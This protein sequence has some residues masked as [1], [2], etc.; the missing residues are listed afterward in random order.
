VSGFLSR[1]VFPC[2]LVLCLTCATLP[3]FGAGVVT[4]ASQA[5]LLSA[6]AGGGTV[7]RA[8]NGT[9]WLTNTITVATNTV[10]IAS[11]HSVTISGSNAVQLFVVP[12]SVTFVLSNLVLADG[13]AQGDGGAISN[14]G[15]VLVIDC[16]FTNNGAQGEGADAYDQIS[17][18]TPGQG[19][20]IYNAGILLVTNCSFL[21]NWA[22]GGAGQY[23]GTS[24]FPVTSGGNGNGGAIYNI[25]YAMIEN[26]V[27]KF[28]SAIGGAPGGYLP[29]SP[30]PS[31]PDAWGQGAVG[32]DVN[33]GAIYNS[34]TL[35]ITNS[36]FE[37]NECIAGLGGDAQL[38]TGAV[39]YGGNGFAGGAGGNASGAGLFSVSGSVSIVGTTFFDNFASGAAGGAGSL[40][41][42]DGSLGG[43][44]GLGGQAVG[45]SACS[46]GG[47]LSI[48]NCT[49]ASNTIV[50]GMGGAGSSGSVGEGSMAACA[51]GNGG[52]GGNA[53]GGAIC[54]SGGSAYVTNATFANNVSI[55]SGGGQGGAGGRGNPPGPDGTNGLPGRA[56]GN[57][58]AV[59]PGFLTLV[60][61]ILFCAPGDT[62]IFGPMIDA[63]YNL[64]SD[65]SGF[66]TNSRSFNG[67]DPVVGALGNYGGPTP[68]IPLLPG[69]I[70]ID[71]ADPKSFPPTDQRG[72]PR[73]FGS[74]PDIGAFEYWPFPP[75]SLS[76]S[77]VPNGIFDLVF[78]GTNG[79]SFSTLASDNLSDWIPISTNT[80]AASNR[81]EML[82]KMNDGAGTFYQTL[83]R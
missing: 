17:S 3:L 26:C 10:L 70:A 52:N 76:A 5:D 51:G 46:A 57:T 80:I 74:A 33:G 75:N 50:A 69:S 34:S 47:T 54:V 22:E 53:A 32:A 37:A 63:G 56:E 1:R 42:E 8:F 2:L 23:T 16:T 66:L 41:V 55:P 72:Y 73:P 36:T 30:P 12:Q 19:G 20:A 82:L 4:N 58:I 59:G 79:Q 65:V 44:G 7:N 83:S 68:T 45:G 60:N 77:R 35:S 18:G 38:M 25:N 39:V 64:S 6:M 43:P 62:N 49:F 61:S 78:W 31:W 27:F 9:I 40:F 67:V 81:F 24:F 21:T 48:V 11:N 71:H 29:P 15:T 28:N 14:S 13:L